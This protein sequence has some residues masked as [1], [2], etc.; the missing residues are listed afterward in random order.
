MTY[1]KKFT[2]VTSNDFIFDSIVVGTPAS[3]T[4]KLSIYNSSELEYSLREAA[5]R[6]KLQYGEAF[7]KLAKE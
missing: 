1:L 5:L 3:F 6:T 7:E 4:S 2:D